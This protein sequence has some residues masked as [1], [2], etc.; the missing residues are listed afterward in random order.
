MARIQTF[1]F[2]AMTLTVRAYSTPLAVYRLK[3]LAPER[4]EASEA[5]TGPWQPVTELEVDPE[6][7]EKAYQLFLQHSGAGGPKDPG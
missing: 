6:Q 5:G 2:E 7:I 4:W 1:D 3:R